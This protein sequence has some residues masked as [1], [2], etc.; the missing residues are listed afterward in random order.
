MFRFSSKIYHIAQFFEPIEKFFEVFAF[1][2]TFSAKASGKPRL[3]LR[4]LSSA[5]ASGTSAERFEPCMEAECFFDGA[6]SLMSKMKSAPSTPTVKR[7][8][9]S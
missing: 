5:K 8:E 2:G 9:S 3:P 7:R 1:A 4:K 6:C